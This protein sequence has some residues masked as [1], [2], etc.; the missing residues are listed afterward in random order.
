MSESRTCPECGDAVPDGRLSC[1]ACGALL[2]TV[3]GRSVP[4]PAAHTRAVGRD[5]DAGFVTASD[6]AAAGD[7]AADELDQPAPAVPPTTMPAV[8]A[9]PSG[10]GSA[11]SAGG[12]RPFATGVS[13]LPPALPRLS[14]SL[15][16][17]ASG[18]AGQW[19][20]NEAAARAARPVP[21]P[22]TPVRDGSDPS[23]PV[24]PPA[25]RPP[26]PS[27]VDLP[28]TLPPGLGPRLVVIGALA[29][30]VAVFLPWASGPGGVVIG[31]GLGLS[32]FAQW[33]L[34]SPGNLLPLAATVLVLAL[35]LMPGRLP[36]WL[37]HGVLP[38]VDGGVLFGIAWTYLASKY[39]V[40][41]GIDVLVLASASLAAGAILVLRH[42]EERPTVT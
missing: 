33:G 17:S 35:A 14:G 6:E 11:A 21:A 8:L 42:A 15:A 3:R 25:A 26:R 30:A 31:G 29:G 13:K 39:T 18:D 16:A 41:I 9:A 24:P 38:L 2:A 32:Y 1:P 27:A 36:E 10:A 12:N 4:A 19:W 5:A 37:A 20:G 22:S 34:A 28:F 23:T 7:P 40:G